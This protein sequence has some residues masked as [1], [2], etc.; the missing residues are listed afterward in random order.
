MQNVQFKIIF[1]GWIKN[2]T[3][4]LISLISLITGI[5]CCT[6]LVTFVIHEYNIAHSILNSKNC[7]LVQE[8][9]KQDVH[10]NDAFISGESGVQLK[11]IYPEVKAYC[12][13]R[14]EHL[15][16]SEKAEESDYMDAYSV[17][18]NFTDFFKL[19][20]L[21]GD[22]RKTLSSPNE[23]AVTRSFARQQFGIANPIGKSLTLGRYIVHF[24]GEKNIYK[25]IFEPCTIT[26]VIDDS[27]KNFLN[28]GILR[29]L[30][31][32]EISKVTGFSFYIFIELSSKVTAPN[33][34]T[35]INDQNEEVF[36][37]R[38]IHLKPVEQ[39]YFSKAKYLYEDGLIFKRDPSFVYLGMG[40]AILIFII[41]CF[42]H[43]NICLTRTIQQ[44]KTTGIQL[45][46]GESKQ[47]IRKQLIMETG[48]LV[49]FSFIV[50]I[51]II[52]VL[53]PYFNTFI[54][55]D[56]SLS[57]LYAGYTPL[58]LILLLGT[59]II[60]PPLYV[61]LKINKNSLS[62]IL[63]N[64]NKQKTI[65]IRNIVITQFTISII[66]TTTVVNIH[67]QMDF[68][69]HCRP[70]AN[71]ILILGWGLYSVEDETIKIFY[72]QLT[73]IPEITHRTMSAITQNC[74]Y[75]LDNMYVDCTDADLSFFDFYDIQLLEGRLFTPGKQGLHEAIVNETFLKK[76]GITEPLGKTFQIWDE[77]FTIVGVVADYPRDKLTREIT[78]L[79]IRFSDT[80]S[81]RH[82]IR[83]QPGTRKIVEEKINAL[84]QQVAPGAIEIKTCSMVERYMEFHE[85]EL[86]VMKILSIF[87]YISILLAGL[88]LFGLAWFSVEN[89]RKEISLRKINGASENQIAVLLCTRFIKW[90][91]IAFCIGA[92]IAYYCSA[93]WLTQFV[94]KNEISPVSFIFIGIAA[95]VIGTLTVAWQAF[96]ASR[97]NP[98]DTIK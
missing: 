90:I 48:L 16:F 85:E 36:K 37:D 57:D 23:I 52:H 68:A 88:G 10:P 8:Q 65:L 64:E 30:P 12:V 39:L 13:F 54:T 27:Q 86:Q 91:L 20:L 7:Y 79:F 49:M 92:P 44:L 6:L 63:K 51:G 98:V 81:E 78:P 77:T 26:T 47:G 76:Q 55:S 69:T 89:R 56:L 61:I 25:K 33:F 70:H 53:I 93:Q 46:S 59:I 3:Y 66:L 87:S 29:G 94:Y 22:L 80:G 4:T 82:I 31:D 71:E 43:I 72:D 24:D 35:K 19:P 96:K 45:I 17:T 60:I 73:S 11:N 40:V 28:F 84:W 83:I 21:S 42:N 97:M 34:L 15:L 50:S 62:E 58:V 18:P 2:K 1:R 9:R 75:G 5:T 38:T 41:A 74:T 14:N 95:V 32:E 67:H